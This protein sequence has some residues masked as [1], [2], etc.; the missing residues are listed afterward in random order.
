MPENRPDLSNVNPEIRTYIEALESE[1]ERYQKRESRSDP[2]AELPAIEEREAPTTFNVISMTAS[3]VAKRT[4]RHLYSRQRRGGMGVF[5]LDTVEEKPP[6]ILTIADAG[7]SILVFTNLARVFRIPV[8]AVQ[9]GP[10]HS[11]GHDILTRLPLDPDEHLVTVLPDLAKGSV[12]MVS[13]KGMVRSLRHHVFGEYMKPGTLM[14]DAK[15][16]GPLKAAR[17]TS[18]NEDVFIVTRHGKAIRFSEKLIPPQGGPGIRL[19]PGDEPV[20]VTSV[21]PE[22][23]VFLLNEDG[24]GTIRLMEGFNPN[25]SPGGSGKIAMT[26]SGLVG[27]ATVEET[28]DIFIISR[29]SKIIRFS[30]AEVPAKEGVVQGVHCI[31]LRADQAV[32]L[33]V[34]PTKLK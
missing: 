10:V 8:K 28:D 20:A 6:A 21:Y 30:A 16:F 5:D 31:T 1:L 11:K 25:K 24:K 22:S 18:G 15:Q 13:K 34:S 33:A 23:G 2:Q 32:T 29:W 26:A 4:P 14:F 27:A 17:W 19:D 3:G 9:E 7:Q 12:V